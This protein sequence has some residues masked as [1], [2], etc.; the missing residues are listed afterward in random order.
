MLAKIKIE[1]HM[2]SYRHERQWGPLG[3][4]L[5]ILLVKCHPLADWFSVTNQYQ[6]I[7]RFS[8]FSNSH[9]N[10]Y[11][12][13]NSHIFHDYISLTLFLVD[14]LSYRCNFSLIFCVSILSI[15]FLQYIL[16]C[17]SYLIDVSYLMKILSQ[18]PL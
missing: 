7:S 16:A 14:I 18:H 1:P 8:N 6:I 12:I 15:Y 2:K 4:P 13:S 11:Y 9:P 3:I 10:S 17:C 5:V